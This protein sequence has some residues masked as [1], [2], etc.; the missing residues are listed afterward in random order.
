LGL[1]TRIV[2]RLN[3]AEFRYRREDWKET[4]QG[5]VF[6][7]TV[8]LGQAPTP[9]PGGSKQRRTIWEVP[10]GTEVGRPNPALPASPRPVMRTDL[11][12]LTRPRGLSLARRSALALR[13]APPPPLDREARLPPP[14][15][16]TGKVVVARVQVSSDQPAR[17]GPAVPL[18]TK[19]VAA[20]TLHRDVVATASVALVQDAFE[21]TGRLAEQALAAV[22]LLTEL[23]GEPGLN[24]LE[25]AIGD[26]A[27]RKTGTSCVFYLGR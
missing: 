19:R 8:R 16:L 2:V 17:T 22:P 3:G 21:K 14:S 23:K 9:K 18:G 7:G 13:K 15:R 26:G 24:V 10:A 25:V 11:L 5:L 6:E 4:A 12:P 27:S 20:W 1:P